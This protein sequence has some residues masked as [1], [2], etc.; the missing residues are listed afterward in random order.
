M[1][2]GGRSR[3]RRVARPSIVVLVII[4]LLLLLL[5][6]L[7]RNPH[8]WRRSHLFVV[9]QPSQQQ[10]HQS[11]HVSLPDEQVAVVVCDGV[12]EYP[13]QTLFGGDAVPQ[14]QRHWQQ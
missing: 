14:Q 6:L 1:P 11:Q 9:A 4:L 7:L 2:R 12:L 10:S 8:R 13:R 3:P 5:L